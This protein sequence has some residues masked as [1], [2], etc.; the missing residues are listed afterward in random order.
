ML[1]TGVFC[2]KKSFSLRFLDSF[3]APQEYLCIFHCFQ[4]GLRNKQVL[5]CISTQK[6]QLFLTSIEEV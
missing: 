5:Q 4:D 2:T 6:V 1:T 3:C